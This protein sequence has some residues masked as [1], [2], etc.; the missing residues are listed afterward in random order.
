M[1]DFTFDNTNGIGSTCTTRDGQQGRCLEIGKCS[2]LPS[3]FLANP[4]TH[5]GFSGFFPI[6]CCPIPTDPVVGDS[7]SGAVPLL[8]IGPPNV[9][10]TF[11]CG[12]SARK[13]ISDLG[14]KK[15]RSPVEGPPVERVPPK[16]SDFPIIGGFESLRN[17]WPWMA[18]LG[19]KEANGKY[20]WFCAGALINDQWILTAAH[21]L[22]NMT[23]EIV[24]LGEHDYND[25]RDE[26]PHKDF[27]IERQIP[28]P[29]Y[30]FPMAYHDLALL[31]LAEKVILQKYI[32]PICLPWG[33]ESRKNLVGRKVKITGWGDTKDFGNPRSK[34]QE[35]DVTVFETS[36]C[37]VKYSKLR[38]FRLTWAN[39]MGEETTCAGDRNGGRD[40]CQGDSGGP[41]IYQAKEI[42]FMNGVVS[43]GYGCGS[44]LYPGVYANV[45]YPPH[46]SWI[47]KVA[48]GNS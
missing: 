14:R 38:E 29:N 5:C 8:D 19:I 26:A 12:R 39:G 42:W 16:D 22:D 7:G 30:T 10:S 36:E 45:Q 17:A 4:P 28:Y 18:L 21:C 20:N 40:A 37:E 43:K 46:L 35:V 2:R 24:R 47:K 33:P 13:P 32:S 25:D 41:S 6:V 34:L 31:K 3:N 15:R 1:K 23:P 11:F 9:G 48:F 27:A 44:R